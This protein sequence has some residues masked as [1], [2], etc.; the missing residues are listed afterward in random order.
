MPDSIKQI[1]DARG[2]LDNLTDEQ[3]VKIGYD[4]HKNYYGSEDEYAKA[5][6]YKKSWSWLPENS[7]ATNTAYQSGSD[8]SSGLQSAL[9][10]SLGIVVLIAV[11][12]W[13][14]YKKYIEELLPA[15]TP[16]RTGLVGAVLGAALTLSVLPHQFRSKDT[17]NAVVA[18]LVLLV[19]YAATGFFLGWVYRKLRPIKATFGVE[20]KPV[21]ALSL[22]QKKADMQSAGAG[23]VDDKPSKK[24]DLNLHDSGQSPAVT[25]ANAAPDTDENH[26][27]SAL[28]ELDGGNRRQ[29][30]WAKAFADSDGDEIRAKVAYLK[31]RVRQL[32]S[33]VDS[34]LT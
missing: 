27:A 33:A 22:L 11:V 17:A 34:G 15:K 29:G 14:I 2:G 18:S 28:A 21:E 26:W 30:I 31:V 12:T 19:M 7:T 32:S 25:A 3:I 23:L 8:G 1:R 24:I 6:G 16:A 4:Q 13:V 20:S 10:E 5:I 9:S